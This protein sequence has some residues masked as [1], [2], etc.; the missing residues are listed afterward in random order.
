MAK[1]PDQKYMAI[2]SVAMGVSALIQ[3]AIRALV[4]LQ[5]S[6]TDLTGTLIYYGLTASMLIIASLMYFIE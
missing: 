3:N 2:A 6:S 5:F 4:L 1:I